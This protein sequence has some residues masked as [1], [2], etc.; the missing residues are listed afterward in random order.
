VTRTLVLVP[1]V[2]FLAGCGTAP[3]SSG[4]SQPTKNDASTSRVEWTTGGSD[5][6]EWASLTTAGVMDYANNEGE[7]VV[8]SSSDS[9]GEMHALFIGRDTYLGANIDGKMRWGKEPSEEAPGGTDRF[10][11]G[12][13]GTK[14]GAVLA[15]LEAAS[16]KVEQ[17]G[18]DKVR[19]VEATHYKAHLDKAKLGKGSDYLPENTVVDAWIDGSGLARRIRLPNGVFD[20]YD[21]GVQVDIE[22]PPADEVLTAEAF[23]KLV[24][25]ECNTKKAGDSVPVACLLF[26]TLT[27][28]S[29]SGSTG[30]GPTETMPTTVTDGK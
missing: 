1:V 2:L 19:D 15:A 4:G 13:R 8:K 27:E 16:T 11:P 17:V 23:E 3:S 24:T 30:Y 18:E 29:G 22:A 10:L 21:Y 12:P 6:P 20:F 26:G 7:L 9:P 25:K 5:V 14:P 28:S